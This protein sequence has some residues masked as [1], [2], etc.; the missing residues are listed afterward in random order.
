MESRQFCAKCRFFRQAFLLWCGTRYG[1]WKKRSDSG[2]L[3]VPVFRREKYSDG[4]HISAYN[5]VGWHLATN[6]F[7]QHVCLLME[8]SPH[9]FFLKK[10]FDPIE[11]C[12]FQ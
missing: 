9:T 4:D 11:K 8:I 12:V 10:Y 5:S 7:H 1:S 6:S 3:S 2:Y